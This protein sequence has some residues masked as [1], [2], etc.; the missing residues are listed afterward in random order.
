M[1]ISKL[2]IELSCNNL[3]TH[4]KVFTG[5]YLNADFVRFPDVSAGGNGDVLNVFWLGAVR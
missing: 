1:K 2:K 3:I 5:C 4:S